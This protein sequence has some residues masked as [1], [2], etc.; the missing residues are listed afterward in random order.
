MRLQHRQSHDALGHQI[1]ELREEKAALEVQ[2]RVLLEQK[3]LAEIKYQSI[4][5]TIADLTCEK[6]AVEKSLR[7][8]QRQ[9]ARLRAQ[10]SA[11]TASTDAAIVGA[12]DDQTESVQSTDDDLPVADEALSAQHLSGQRVLCVGGRPGSISS[13]RHAVEKMGGRFDHHDGGVEQKITKLDPSLTGADMV[14]CLA[15]CVS[16]D[17]YW[18]VKKHCRRNGK[19]CIFVESSG[20][21]SLIRT[22][23][24]ASENGVEATDH[25]ES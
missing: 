1:N 4:D 22:L 6:E 13:Y 19:R 23:S 25:A 9:V 3:R 24:I 20:V 7:H 21:Q 16:H 18:R 5:Q 14:L 12:S 10:L 15:G 2:N 17:A 8:V 11:G